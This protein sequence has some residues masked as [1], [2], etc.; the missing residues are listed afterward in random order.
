MAGGGFCCGSKNGLGQAVRFTQPRWQRDATDFSSG[1]IVLP[2]RAG[3]E[4]ADD[5]FNRKRLRL[6]HDHGAACEF[7]FE[8]VER[9]REI[10]GAEYVVGDYI[11]QQMEPEER[12]LREDAALVGNRRGQDDVESGEP[13]RC[14]DQE[15]VIEIVDV[16]A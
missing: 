2:A 14:D 10:R 5:A 8:R 13:V 4:T 3:D 1:P 16:T 15:L 12:K 6:L 11:L 7:L 9:R